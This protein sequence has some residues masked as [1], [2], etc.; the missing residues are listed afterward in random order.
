[1]R[2][3]SLARRSPPHGHV[4]FHSTAANSGTSSLWAA[5]P[6]QGADSLLALSDSLEG[7]C[8]HCLTH[9]QRTA[10]YRSCALHTAPW[11]HLTVSLQSCGPLKRRARC[12]SVACLACSLTCC[13]AQRQTAG[14]VMSVAMALMK[15]AGAE[16]YTC[17]KRCTVSKRVL[18]AKLQVWV[19]AQL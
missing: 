2:Y 18:R 14:P 3:I 1:M 11:Q 13:V 12:S 17:N 19:P 4:A 5:L 16:A 10:L 8:G 7:L 9:A 6:V 15:A